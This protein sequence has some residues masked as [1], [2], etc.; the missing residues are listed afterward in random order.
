[1]QAW[2]SDRLPS[3]LSSDPY[4]LIGCAGG[5]SRRTGWR[6]HASPRASIL[7]CPF[8]DEVG[9]CWC[10]LPVGELREVWHACDG[11]RRAYPWH[12]RAS[13]WYHGTCSRSY[14][15]RDWGHRARA[16]GCQASPGSSWLHS[17]LLGTQHATSSLRPQSLRSCPLTYATHLRC[18]RCW[19]ESL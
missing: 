16:S 10:H 19:S 14:P 18:V 1:M 8:S 15:G 7:D 4:A 13:R 17:Q 2:T 12:P 5:R 11:G 9:L 3:W 6:T